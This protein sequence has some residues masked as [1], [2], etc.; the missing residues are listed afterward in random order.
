MASV[1]P[2]ANLIEQNVTFLSKHTKDETIWEGRILGQFTYAFARTLGDIVSYHTNV[3][4]NDP[5][6]PPIETL[7]FFV[8][9]LSAK[10][11]N[12]SEPRVFAKEWILPNSFEI[13]DVKND[14]GVRV[15]GVPDTNQQRILDVLRNAGFRAIIDRNI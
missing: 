6:V 10:K 9:Q 3:Q 11:S 14:I 13:L 8:I 1:P 12:T 7:D 2:I 15:L 5:N 4:R